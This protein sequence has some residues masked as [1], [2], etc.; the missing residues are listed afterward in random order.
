MYIP[1]YYKEEDTAKLLGFMRTNSFALLVNHSPAG[2]QATHLP[3]VVE[4]KE[5]KIVLVSHMSIANPHWKALEQDPDALV[6]F[7]GPH[8]Y[9]S[10]DNYEKQQNVP[11]WNYI[12]VHAKG[13]VRIYSGKEELMACL[14]KMIST[15]EEKFMQQW[16]GL[17]ADYAEAMLKGIVAFEVVVE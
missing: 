8:A 3:F 2:L 7:S 13:K 15:Y 11:T 9:I 16:Q 10:P 14:N 17:S 12:A 4:Q 5:E 1:R 6:I